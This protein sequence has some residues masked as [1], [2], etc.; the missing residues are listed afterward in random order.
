MLSV[1]FK[2]S[3][4]KFVIVVDPQYYSFLLQNRPHLIPSTF[5]LGF[6]YFVRF[7]SS[8]STF[9]FAF[10]TDRLLV[11]SVIPDLPGGELNLCEFCDD[12]FIFFINRFV[13]VC[14]R[15]EGSFKII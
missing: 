5:P 1:E 13:Y 9:F 8:I 7:K 4:I 14:P 3:T 12:I 15:V 2:F 11:V 6:K 10:E